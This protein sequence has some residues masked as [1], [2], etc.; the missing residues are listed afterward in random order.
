MSVEPGN[1]FALSTEEMI[2]NSRPAIDITLGSCAFVLKDK[3]IGILLSGA[4]RDGA[5]GMKSIADKGGLTIVQEP[6]ECMID[7]MPQAALA[8]A[9]IDHVLKINE[10]IEFFNELDNK[11]R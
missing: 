8:I 4:N 5:A 10:M 11:Y 2:N 6:A 9:R 3:L 7:T 1:H